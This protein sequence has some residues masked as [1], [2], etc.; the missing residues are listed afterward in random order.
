MSKQ[1]SVYPFY[2][3]ASIVVNLTNPK[4]AIETFGLTALE[5]MA[6]GLPTIVPKEGGIAELVKDGING[7]KIDVEKLNEINKQIER[8][9]GD[10]TLYIRLSISAWELSK[11]YNLNTMI[12]TI[13]NL[14]DRA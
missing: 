7:Y 4:Y 13:D 14:I 11:C 1:M 3:E 8:I 5:A 12:S 9:L 2:A 10:E 6:A